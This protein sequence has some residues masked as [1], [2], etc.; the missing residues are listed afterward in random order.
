[1]AG[2]GARYETIR[3][4]QVDRELLDIILAGRVQ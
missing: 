2:L 3:G 1:M 4:Y